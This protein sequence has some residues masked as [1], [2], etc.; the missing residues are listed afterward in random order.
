MCR[1]LTGIKRYIIENKEQYPT[2][3]DQNTGQIKNALLNYLQEYSADGT[4]QMLDRIVLS[5]SSMNNDKYTENILISAFDE[6][7][8]IDDEFIRD[9][10]NNLVKYAYF[11][12]YDN[13]GVNNFFNL[14]PVRWKIQHGYT[15]EFRNALLNFGDTNSIAGSM[16]SEPIDDPKSGYYSSLATT[17][18]R[19]MWNNREIVKPY[20]FDADNGDYSLLFAQDGSN[21]RVLFFSKN[22]KDRFINM[23]GDLFRKVGEIMLSRVDDN[24]DIFSSK[25]GV[26]LLTPKLGIEDNGTHV[27]E[28]V[29]SST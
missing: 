16:I 5:N 20:K 13:S 10:A 12:T 24:T 17:I 26:Y 19:N 21:K 27:Y 28:Y 22:A 14:V 11:S 18:A 8:T 1:Q 9:F 7:L 2:L 15:R 23:N 3:V 29:N 25:R 6:L 4:K